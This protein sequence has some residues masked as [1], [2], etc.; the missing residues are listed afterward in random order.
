MPCLILILALLAPRLVLFFIWL[1][2]SW[3]FLAFR[4]DVLLPLLGF[5]FMPYTTLAY[6]AAATN[7]GGV[8]GMWLVLLILAV[9]VDASHLGWGEK[10]RRSR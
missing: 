3:F 2:T 6:L 10:V 8:H 5:F 7:G 4:G 9:L 1:L